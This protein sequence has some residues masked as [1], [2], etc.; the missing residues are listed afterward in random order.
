MK[1]NKPEV[2]FNGFSGDWES[3]PFKENFDNIRNNTLSRADL[4]NIIGL[5]KNIHY[6]DVLIKFGELLD[7]KKEE[8][9]FITDDIISTKLSPNKL[10]NGDVIIADAAEDSTVGKCTELI[11]VE[12]DVVISGLH[13]IAVRSKVQFAPKYLGYFMN[14]SAYHNQL[15]RL[16]QGTKVLSISKTAIKDTIIWAPTDKSEQTQIGNFFQ[17]LD[18]LISLHQKK[19]D[20]LVI[21]KKAMLEKMFPKPGAKVPEIRFKGFE[22]DWEDKKLGDIGSVA[23]NKRI[24]K[25]QTS[26]LGEIPF[27]KIGTF[28][29]E[30]DSYISK[31]LFD[32]YKKKFPYP[33]LGDILISA[34]GSIGR[35][36]EY[37]GVDEYFQDSNIVWLDH[38]GQINNLFLKQFYTIVK[39]H[40]LE[41]STIKRL[42]N[43]NILE[44]KIFLPSNEE[45]ERLGNHFQNLDKLISLN[46][47]Q[48]EKLKNIKKACLEKMF[49]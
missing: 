8:I 18:Q 43:K 12:D 25:F 10:Q 4:N 34:S 24:Y 6:G 5:A 48:L 37:L 13:T 29:G 19:Y 44:T 16:M 46:Q 1:K 23:M 21:L 47:K 36:V 15:L 33:C 42:Y 45:Q 20:K 2:R 41:G 38:K 22:G 31:E 17:N 26:V 30:A 28:G 11:N 39:W 27:Y 7:V 49:V 32:D 9:P 35:T 40:G 3:L 14:S